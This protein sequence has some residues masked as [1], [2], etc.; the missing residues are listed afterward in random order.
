MPTTGQGIQEEIFSGATTEQRCCQG[1]SHI[2]VVVSGDATDHSGQGQQKYR[3][4]FRGHHQIQM[5]SRY[6]V[7]KKKCFRAHHRAC[8][9]TFSVY[10][11]KKMFSATTPKL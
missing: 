5:F 3:D 9:D 11:P 4:I 10:P 6:T 7:N 8:S 1:N 2:R